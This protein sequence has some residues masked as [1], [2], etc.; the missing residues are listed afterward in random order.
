MQNPLGLLTTHDTRGVGGNHAIVTSG[1]W[2]SFYF[3]F[4]FND[5][6]QIVLQHAFSL[7]KIDFSAKESQFRKKIGWLIIILP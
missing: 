3:F 5:R 2:F 6:K 1:K 7:F 4:V